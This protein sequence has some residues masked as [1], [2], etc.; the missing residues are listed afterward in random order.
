M[1]T[2][3]YKKQTGLTMLEILIVMTLSVVLLSGLVEIVLAHQQTSR[4]QKGLSQIQANGRHAIDYLR[5]DMR[6]A[7]YAGCLPGGLVNAH[8][9]LST[10]LTQE[11]QA[12]LIA[13]N[14]YEQSFSS[15]NPGA[16]SDSVQV[17]SALGTGSN[18]AVDMSSES[19]A[20]EVV[21]G[22][23]I[24]KNSLVVI[25]NCEDGDIFAV[26]KITDNTGSGDFDDCAAAGASCLLEHTTGSDNLNATLSKRYQTDAR[27]FPLQTRLYSIQ[28]EAGKENSLWVSNQGKLVDGIENMQVLYGEDGADADSTADYYVPLNNVTDI[29]NVVSLKINLLLRSGDDH[30][31]KDAMKYD[32]AGATN[33]AGPDKRLRKVFTTTIALRNKLQ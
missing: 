4:L 24:K 8:S 33:L 30:L 20:I 6:R 18:L 29:S 19:A 23:D 16:N 22:S 9:Q 11:Y 17:T 31:S 14:S 2:A 25:S 7:G 26:T 27:V 3:H 1:R 15:T 13:D 5:M 10:V 12:A 32:F 28:I 21:G